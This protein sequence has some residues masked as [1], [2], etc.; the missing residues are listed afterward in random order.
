MLPV[1]FAVFVPGTGLQLVLP[2]AS[3]SRGGTPLHPGQ[4]KSAT[5]LGKRN[6]EQPMVGTF[7][8][9]YLCEESLHIP[10]IHAAYRVRPAGDRRRKE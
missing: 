10:G 2:S 6:Q 4:T 8:S 5:T 9:I 1:R 3:H 7:P